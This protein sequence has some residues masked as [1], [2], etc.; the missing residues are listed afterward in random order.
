MWIGWFGRSVPVDTAGLRIT[1]DGRTIS[2]SGRLG[3]SRDADPAVT[4][5]VGEVERLLLAEQATGLADHAGWLPGDFSDTLSG[6]PF[7]VRRPGGWF[8]VLSSQVDMSDGALGA[9]GDLRWSARFERHAST[10]PHRWFNVAVKD[11]A[12]GTNVPGYQAAWGFPA[13]SSAV[14]EG[15]IAFIDRDAGARLSPTGFIN[16]APAPSFTPAAFP[17]GVADRVVRVDQLTDPAQLVYDRVGAVRWSCDPGPAMGGAC[18]VAS[19]DASGQV[20]PTDGRTVE[21]TQTFLP[22]T[23]P[24]WE[25]G[26][27]LI[28]FRQSATAGRINAEWHVGG[29]WTHL[30]SLSFGTGAGAVPAWRGI[31]VIRNT[32]EA[33]TVELV[34][35]Q[36]PAGT[37][38]I[39]VIRGRVGAYIQID[40]SPGSPAT[41]GLFASMNQASNTGLEHG[42]WTSAGAGRQVLIGRGNVAT[43]TYTLTA[44]SGTIANAV[45]ATQ[46]VFGVTLG[47]VAGFPS[48]TAALEE[49]RAPMVLTEVR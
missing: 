28:R 33:A 24:S 29:V 21:A 35:A 32:H 4:E 30:R 11:E 25:I 15:E 20:H 10:R 26:N 38:T 5:T 23:S 34:A 41:A 22:A 7:G 39:T 12:F 27:G 31:R 44:A 47:G 16:L 48:V 40:T 13:L 45:S 1:Q 2:V 36:R 42:L 46:R 49:L 17:A 37:V 18:Y 6:T 43:P 8:R 9:G 19:V 14:N 3:A